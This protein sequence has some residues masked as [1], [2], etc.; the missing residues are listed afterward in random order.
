MNVRFA[1]PTLLWVLPLLAAVLALWFWLGRK[2]ISAFEER[3]AHRVSSG[4]WPGAC[5]GEAD[6]DVAVYLAATSRGEDPVEAFR[7][8]SRRSGGASVSTGGPSDGQQES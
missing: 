4:H 2:L 6:C 1:V 5:P 3:V 7:E 8:R